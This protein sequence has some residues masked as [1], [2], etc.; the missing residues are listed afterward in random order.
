MVRCVCI[1]RSGTSGYVTYDVK[2]SATLL[3]PLSFPSSRK[4]STTEFQSDVPGTLVVSASG[5]ELTLADLLAQWSGEFNCGKIRCLEF[6]AAN[7]LARLVVTGLWPRLHAVGIGTRIRR[8]CLL[9]RDAPS[10]RQIS[11]FQSLLGR[12]EIDDPRPDAAILRSKVQVR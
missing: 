7:F 6:Y 10:K 3:E 2:A 8:S 9:V 4:R 12:G 1:F 11:F 5:H